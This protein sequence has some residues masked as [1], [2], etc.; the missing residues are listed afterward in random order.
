MNAS[1]EG[2]CYGKADRGKAAER[3][4]R[5]ERD[6][7]GW[8]CLWHMPVD[9]VHCEDVCRPFLHRCGK[10]EVRGGVVV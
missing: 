7:D 10:V 2:S 6:R 8:R 3:R 4:A 5:Q 9:N 1:T